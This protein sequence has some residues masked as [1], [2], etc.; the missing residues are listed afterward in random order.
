MNFFPGPNNLLALVH[1]T[2][3]N[4]L[5]VTLGRLPL[6]V[7]LLLSVGFKSPLVMSHAA[8][9]WLRWIG[10]GYLLWMAWQAFNTTVVVGDDETPLKVSIM[11][12]S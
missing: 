9:Q 8:F 3:T 4:G 6:M 12:M 5:Q 7:I 11:R 1:G 10:A 2:R